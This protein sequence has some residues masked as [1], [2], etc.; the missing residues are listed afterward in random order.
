MAV[1]SGERPSP[2]IT[3][4]AYSLMYAPWTDAERASK[5]LAA[6]ASV[7]STPITLAACG[8]DRSPS[9]S[10]AVQPVV[11]SIGRPAISSTYGL[12]ACARLSVSSGFNVPS[13][14]F[15]SVPVLMFISES[16]LPPM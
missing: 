12:M 6:S 10:L 16:L 15:A 7:P 9:P 8:Y 13:D 4:L 5:I 14:T 2:S 3:E 11:P 1:E